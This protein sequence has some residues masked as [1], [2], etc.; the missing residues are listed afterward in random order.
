VL[1]RTIGLTRCD[2]CELALLLLETND[3]AV[4]LNHGSGRL[5]REQE[6]QIQARIIKLTIAVENGAMA[7]GVQAWQGA[8][9]LLAVDATTGFEAGRSREEVIHPQP[10]PV[11]GLLNG[12]LGR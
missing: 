9:Q 7:I 8:L 1:Q 3:R 6:Q 12:P 4:P 5:S 2:T 10:H 11:I